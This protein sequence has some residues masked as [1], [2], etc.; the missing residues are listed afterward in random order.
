MKVQE[1][2][3]LWQA[4]SSQQQTAAGGVS[5]PVTV[6][7]IRYVMTVRSPPPAGPS[8]VCVDRS[9]QSYDHGFNQQDTR[10]FGQHPS[11]LHIDHGSQGLACHDN[12]EA[13]RLEAR[14]YGFGFGSS[15]DDS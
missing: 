13:S 11:S 6:T 2:I 4:G 1:V 10:K 8:G 5:L 3:R 12:L 7:L 9:S 15:R 14:S